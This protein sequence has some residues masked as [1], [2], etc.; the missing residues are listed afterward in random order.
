MLPR[1]VL[2]F[3]HPPSPTVSAYKRQVVFDRSRY[4]FSS[5]APRANLRQLVW[6]S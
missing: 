2:A 3:E 4:S 6:Q 5:E 1:Y